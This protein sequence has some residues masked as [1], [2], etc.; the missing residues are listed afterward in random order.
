MEPRGGAEERRKFTRGR[1]LIMDD[2]FG[3]LIVRAQSYADRHPTA[4]RCA[5][6]AFGSLGYVALAGVVALVLAGASGLCWF[7][8]DA[9][10]GPLPVLLSLWFALL[11][12]LVV[13]ALRAQAGPAQG[14]FVT[15]REAPPLHAVIESVRSRLDAPPVRAVL[16]GTGF[17]ISVVRVP[18]LGSLLGF[19]DHLVLGLPLMLALP[20]H[21]FRALLAHEL[22]HFSRARG[23]EGSRVY[24]LRD[25]WLQLSDALARS[26]HPAAAL[27][28]PFFRWYAPRFAAWSLPLA[29]RHEHVADR[30]AARAT[31]RDD[32]AH[33]LIRRGVIQCFLTER[34]Y[35]RLLA[36]LREFGVPPTGLQARL[37]RALRGI[38]G[39]HRFG[40][41]LD[42]SM[43][44]EALTDSH[45]ATSSRLA[46]LGMTDGRQ[47]DRGLDFEPGFAET[48]GG[49][50]AARHCLG[51]LST[52]LTLSLEFAWIE[53]VVKA[54]ADRHEELLR[55]DERRRQLEGRAD[56][57]PGEALDLAIS[58]ATIEGSDAALP[59][60]R[61][62]VT[63][64]PDMAPARF[65]LGTL[66]LRRNEPE[67][68]EQIETA[69][70]L[71]SGLTADGCELA[72]EFLRA[73]GKHDEA[74]E[75]LGRF[76][77]VPGSGSTGETPATGSEIPGPDGAAMQA[78]EREP[79]SSDSG[80]GDNGPGFALGES[81]AAGEAD[82][83]SADQADRGYHHHGLEYSEVLTAKRGIAPM[84]A[85][86]RAFLVREVGGSPAL[87]AGA[88][89][90]PSQRSA[91]DTAG[92]GSRYLL[93]VEL[94]RGEHD[95]DA[96]AKRLALE[97]KL[98]GPAVVT[99]MTRRHRTL[100]R[101]L[102][103]ARGA[104]LFERT[105]RRAA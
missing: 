85:V 32:L 42:R 47:A 71:D 90:V 55:W 82:P 67:G 23:V 24:R 70:E 11:T 31:G 8:A 51:S 89:T 28:R 50:S 16:I 99:V 80:F 65:V 19:R 86:A 13:S 35:P 64:Q 7:L 10:V 6:G 30:L 66:L 62:L 22:A 44:L 102:A 14:L 75:F 17:D 58:T 63:R 100:R 4:Y 43:S 46:A 61:G 52:E 72:C 73:H 105:R 98:P 15:R 57:S 84:A 20:L 25:R 34:F 93:A 87:P 40:A 18:R 88:V 76:S 97:V 1:R 59:I 81:Q 95:P 91:G 83:M 69:I 74:V 2:R 37:T 78:T 48:L 54:W 33:A 39:D 92:S 60:L 68:L 94:M 96:I 9:G 27:I 3:E 56:L 21:Q 5:V 103:K 104:L 45:A 49:E 26:R 29:R 101:A 38:R 77:A 12:L 36:D 79:P 53:D 41:W